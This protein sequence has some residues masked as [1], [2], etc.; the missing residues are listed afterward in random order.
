M[1]RLYE[2]D[3]VCRGSLVPKHSADGVIDAD[4]PH[5]SL[6]RPGC[7]SFRAAIL[8]PD[9]EEAVFPAVM[10]PYQTGSPLDGY[11][12]TPYATRPQES[13]P[14]AL[15]CG[16]GRFERPARLPLVFRASVPSLARR[17]VRLYHAGRGKRM[18]LGALSLFVF[19]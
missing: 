12:R 16:R 19:R 18:A 5:S 14:I 11:R 2:R 15:P 1:A 10:E 3:G 4:S 6:S 7:P 8:G 9:C 13:I 17:V